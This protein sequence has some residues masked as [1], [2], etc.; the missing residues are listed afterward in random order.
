MIIRRAA[1][2]TFESLKSG[3]LSASDNLEEKIAN[4]SERETYV[5]AFI[6]TYFDD[7]REQ[8]KQIDDKRKAG[9]R[10]GSLQGMV[11]AVKNVIAIRDRKL[12][13]GSKML[14]NYVA[15]YDA[16]VIERIRAEDG[17]I[18]GSTNCDEFACG[19]DTTKSAFFSTINPVSFEDTNGKFSPQPGKAEY[20]PGGSSGGSAAAVAADFCDIALG[21]DTG[22][23][24][25]CPAAFC[26][27][28]GMKPSYGAVPRY[29]MADMTMSFEQIGAFASD[30]FG[31]AL[32]TSVIE[33]ADRRDS[34]TAKSKSLAAPDSNFG[35][36]AFGSKIRL[37]VP[38][39][40]FEG[41]DKEV[42]ATVRAAIEKIAKNTGFEIVS[43][44]IPA[45]K[46]CIPAYYLIVYSEFASA[47]QKY[48]GF[49]YGAAAD[50]NGD[51][52]EAPSNIRAKA[53]G[54]ECQ[55][56]IIL[57]TYI[58]T[59]E[60]KDAWYTKALKARAYLKSQVED[61]LKKCDVLVGPT[62]PMTAWKNGEMNSDPLQQYLAD[63]LTV[64]S[65]LAGTPA[66]S[67]PC[68]KA[69]GLPVGLQIIGKIGDDA[70][71]L[72]LM[73]SASEALK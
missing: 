14:E 39:E 24:I 72:S 23:S 54:K 8:A 26:G 18:I 9:K 44:D 38:K 43:V 37:G 3:K 2:E 70:K 48:D 42:S 19:T 32:L 17:V 66:A 46:Y 11:V 16:T 30:A 6:E 13:C 10:V 25:R 1:K 51:L 41:A 7:A 36:P 55:R 62:M 52:V 65:N 15:P 33:G 34:T 63:I 35:K 29:G 64:P 61:A 4:I 49:K 58:T 57:G 47:M 60:H 40:F 22:G 68:G 73:Q 31:V 67:I 71:V 56:R 20:V 5:R 69:G 45:I 53:I 12:T 50:V 59:K 21:T 27:I 28:Y